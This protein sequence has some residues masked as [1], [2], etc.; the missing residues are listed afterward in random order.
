LIWMLPLYMAVSEISARE[1]RTAEAAG[2]RRIAFWTGMQFGVSL[3]VLMARETTVT[4]I[5]LE[6]LLPAHY[7]NG[8][9]GVVEM[10]VGRAP[11][12]ADQWN[13]P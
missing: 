1:G 10:Y 8:R 5:A 12:T 6:G 2:K 13:G 11:T 9:H 7:R 3:E 4:D